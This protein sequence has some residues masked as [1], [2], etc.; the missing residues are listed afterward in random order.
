MERVDG[1]RE[2]RRRRWRD[3]A[4][5]PLDQV[6]HPY[7]M[8][9]HHRTAGVIRIRQLSGRD[10]ERTTAKVRIV[11]LAHRKIEEREQP[12]PRIRAQG[13]EFA[14]DYATRKLGA[15]REVGGDELVLGCEVRIERR[16]RGTC[17]SQNAI[18]TD[19]AD[20]LSIKQP[21]SSFEQSIADRPR[22]RR[23]QG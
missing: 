9:Q 19:R 17:L 23:W 3:L 20:A 16:F 13:I 10:L 2:L 12:L 1:M 18:D 7:A 8:L 11:A 5:E 14:R 6:P 15:I 22:R 4:N 21:V